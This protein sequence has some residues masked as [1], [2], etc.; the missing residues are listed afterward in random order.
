MSLSTDRELVAGILSELDNLTGFPY[1]SPDAN[2]GDA[3]PLIERLD[4]PG[5]FNMQAV[6][7]IIVVLPSDEIAASQW[8]DAK[9]QEVSDALNEKFGNVTQIEIGLLSTEVGTRNAMILTVTR[10]A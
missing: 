6:W 3:W 10:G 1:R 2:A 5:G 7:R 4:S 9:F 8:F